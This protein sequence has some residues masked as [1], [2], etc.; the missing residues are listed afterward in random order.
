MEDQIGALPQQFV[1]AALAAA[2]L[3]GPN[4]QRVHLSSGTL[5]TEQEVKS[6]L[7]NTEKNLLPKLKDG[8]VV[9]A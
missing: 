9:I 2:N 5:K 4:T 3:L 1:R 7:A 8:P 6:W